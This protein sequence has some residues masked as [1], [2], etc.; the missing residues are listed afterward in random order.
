M[1]ASPCSV[2][3][4]SANYA[5]SCG[6]IYC[7]TRCQNADWESGHGRQYHSNVH[8][9]LHPSPRGVHKSP[10]VGKNDLINMKTNKIAVFSIR[11]LS[12]S[13]KT[14]ICQRLGIVCYD[15]DDLVSEVWQTLL[16]DPASAYKQLVRRNS[17]EA[18]AMFTERKKQRVRDLIQKA[19]DRGE[20]IAFAGITIDVPADKEFF[21]EMPPEDLEVAYRRVIL[22]EIQKVLD[23]AEAAKRIVKHRDID[24]V[25]DDLAY[26]FHIEAINI[27]TSFDEYQDMYKN[28]LAY[29]LGRKTRVLTQEKI[30]EQLSKDLQLARRIRGE[31]A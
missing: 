5:C 9:K 16:D 25:S 15:T 30:I 27:T 22:R 26:R 31:R 1:D 17:E 28:A 19:R 10:N 14:Y 24:F 12:G 7:S 18:E 20:D 8:A 11:G 13:G 29:E 4:Y 2:C 21:I 3:K 23:H 6:I